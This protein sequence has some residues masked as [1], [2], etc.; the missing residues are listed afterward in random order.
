MPLTTILQLQVSLLSGNI[1]TLRLNLIQASIVYSL[2]EGGKTEEEVV[3]DLNTEK[4]LIRSFL[5]AAQFLRLDGPLFA[6]NWDSALSG[7]QDYTLQVE[8]K[9]RERKVIEQDRNI[10]LEAGIVRFIKRK[11]EAMFEEVYGYLCESI[12]LFHPQPAVLFPL[13]RW[14]RARFRSW[15]EE[16]L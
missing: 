13:G 9:A 16:I 6:I 3:A 12:K 10:L 2:L 5:E 15:R 1:L 11:K 8:E 4:T 14:L 7:Q